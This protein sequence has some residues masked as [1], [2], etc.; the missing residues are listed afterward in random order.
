MREPV[1]AYTDETDTEDM[2][3]RSSV[4]FSQLFP[5]SLLA[6]SC[7]VV[8]SRLTWELPFVQSPSC[9]PKWTWIDVGVRS[10]RLIYGKH[11]LNS[12]NEPEKKIR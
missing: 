1:F 10:N 9:P 12:F 5:W 7:P 8:V 6:N 2:D 4:I 11:W 3:G